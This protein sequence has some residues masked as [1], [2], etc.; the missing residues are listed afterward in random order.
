VPHVHPHTPHELGEVEE[1]ERPR[2]ARRERMLE[3]GAVLLLSFATVATAYS[4][5]QAALWAGEQSS[6]YAQ[7]STLRIHA[8]QQS[9]RAGQFRIEDLLLFNR[10]LDAQDAGN[11][12]LMAIYQ[13]RF[14]ARFRPAF[15]AWIAEHPFTNPRAR[16]SPLYMPQYHIAEVARADELDAA[17]NEHYDAGTTAKENDDN[18]ILSTVF[19]AAVLF[20]AGISLRLDWFPLRIAVMGFGT[21]MLLGGAVFVLSLPGA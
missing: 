8:Q 18:Y 15:Q 1:V 11:R 7:A 14:R 10:W 12:K 2:P 16:P 20:F 4:G 13:R 17:A 9:T 6:E 21:A 19:F 3:L 5:Y